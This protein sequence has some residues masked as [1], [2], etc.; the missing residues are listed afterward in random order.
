MFLSHLAV[1]STGA[2]AH[3]PMSALLSMVSGFNKWKNKNKRLNHPPSRASGSERL[4]W[5][6]D[7]IL[8]LPTS[9][10]IARWKYHHFP[11]SPTPS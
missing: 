7:G 5:Q 1:C 4:H 11:L 2:H 6:G 3:M 9:F 10:L 8:S